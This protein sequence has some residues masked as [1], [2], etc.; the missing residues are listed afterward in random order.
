MKCERCKKREAT[1]H[2]TEIRNSEKR[3]VHLCEHCATD[4]G[5]PGKQHFTIQELLAGMTQAQQRRTRTENEPACARCGLRLSQFQSSG[6]FGC[7]DCYNSFKD[8]VLPLVEKIHDNSQH[9]GRAPKHVS[10]EVGLQKEI[11]QLQTEQKK[12]IRRQDY[13]AAARLR[14]R[15]HELQKRL[16]APQSSEDLKAKE[17]NKGRRGGAKAESQ[18]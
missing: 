17:K 11:R 14:D 10:E 12:A 16:N 2:L 7:A 18:D 6:R 3:E 1:V 8:E 4:Q 5:L 9:V 13:E 15:I